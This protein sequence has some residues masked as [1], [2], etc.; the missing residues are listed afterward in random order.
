MSYRV[1]GTKNLYV[2]DAS[3]LPFLPSGNINAAIIMI[4]AIA[5]HIIKQ[6]AKVHLNY[7][8]CSKSYN[9]YYI[10]NH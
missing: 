3:I 4:A 10:S 5:A 9:Y 6:N 1:Y 8:K 2:V 7:T